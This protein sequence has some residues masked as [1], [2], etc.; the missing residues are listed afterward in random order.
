MCSP[1]DGWPMAIAVVEADQKAA[2]GID[3]QQR[4]LRMF[5]ACHGID[6]AGARAG[7]VERGNWRPADACHRQATRGPFPLTPRV[8]LRHVHTDRFPRAAPRLAGG[9]VLRC[10]RQERVGGRQ[11]GAPILG[12]QGGVHFG[13]QP[14]AI[15][16]RG[17]EPLAVPTCSLAAT[18]SIIPGSLRLKRGRRLRPD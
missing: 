6:L 3:P 4:P 1:G 10:D 17:F 8:Q 13:T 15:V 2:D 11:H 5:I 16:G 18:S 12:G 7:R 14:V 9:D